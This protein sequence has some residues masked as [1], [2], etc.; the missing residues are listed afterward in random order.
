MHMTVCWWNQDNTAKWKYVD[1][2]YVQAKI[3]ITSSY[4]QQM[5]P[6]VL[7]WAREDRLGWDTD[8]LICILVKHWWWRHYEWRKPKTN[9]KKQTNK[10]LQKTVKINRSVTSEGRSFLYYLDS[11]TLSLIKISQIF[12]VKCPS[13]LP[14][15]LSIFFY[16]FHA[17]K[18]IQNHHFLS[19]QV[20]PIFGC[21][22]WLWNDS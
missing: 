10:W 19:S 12:L 11:I 4:V 2:K 9:K 15:H 14:V 20:C 17:K 16:S 7:G 18:W 1:S 13:P 21:F 5:T 6:C 8:A 22:H 3:K